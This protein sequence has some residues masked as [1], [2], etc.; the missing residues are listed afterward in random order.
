MVEHLHRQL[1]AAIRCHQRRWTEAL[2]QVLMG[3][4]TSWK[5]ELGTTAAEM[6]YGQPMRLPG[7]FLTPQPTS[8]PSCSATLF[9]QHLKAAFEDLRPSS[10]GRHGEKKVFVLKDLSTAR[11]VFIRN[12]GIKRPLKQSYSGPYRVVWRSD[13]CFTVNVSGQDK[14]I[15][16]D[17]L[18]PAFILAEDIETGA[19][20]SSERDDRILVSLPGPPPV[21]SVGVPSEGSREDNHRTRYG[22]RIRFPETAGR[23]FVSFTTGSGM[24]W[25]LLSPS[26][27]LSSK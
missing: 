19:H 1:K 14:T 11:H 24:M 15:S 4:R 13:K 18:K 8:K 20:A 6:V 23:F 3:I 7:Q 26:C 5:E 9:V 16:V 17:R 12:D 25:G 22:R 2:S 21:T 10:V 27:S